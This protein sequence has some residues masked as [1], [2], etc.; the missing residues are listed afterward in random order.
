MAEFVTQAALEQAMD[1]INDAPRDHAK[2]ECLCFREGYNQRAFPQSLDFTVDQGVPDER[3]LS[4]PWMRLPDGSPDPRIQVSLL[5]KRV[6]DTVWLDREN[7]VHPGDTII[8]DLNTSE[9]ALPVG[10]RLAMGAAVIEVTDAFNEGCVKWKARY[11]AAAKDWITMGDH[12]K[13]RLRGILC[14]IVQDGRVTVGDVI[15]RLD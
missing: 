9:E 1:W 7:T 11:G 14:R 4:A 6:M 10:T 12:P 3:W 5:S 2:I 8:A 15:T 13:L